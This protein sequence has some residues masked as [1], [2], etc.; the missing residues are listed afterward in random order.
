[1]QPSDRIIEAAH[2]NVIVYKCLSAMRGAATYERVLEEMVVALVEQNT[3]AFKRIMDLEAI[4]P[5]TYVLH[6]GRRLIYRCPDHLVP[7]VE[8]CD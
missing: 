4:A 2:K 3:A 1:M 6:D 8:L 5:K 7:V